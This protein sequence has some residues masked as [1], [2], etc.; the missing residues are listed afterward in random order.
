MTVLLLVVAAT[1]TVEGK[2]S[3]SLKKMLKKLFVD[4]TQ[5]QLLVADDKL[6]RSIKVSIL[7][8]R[9]WALFSS[10]S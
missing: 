5:Q 10:L 2:M 8:L 7:P 4:E 1:A 3:K 9:M 6:G